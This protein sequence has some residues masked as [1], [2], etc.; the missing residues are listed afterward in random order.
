MATASEIYG[1]SSLWSWYGDGANDCS[2]SAPYDYEPIL[3]SFGEIAV[4]EDTD[5]YQGDSWVLYRDGDR[6]G[7]LCFGWGSCSG[8]DSLQGCSNERELDELIARL[9][10]DVKWGSR[11]EI[12]AFIDKHDWE[13]AWYGRCEPAKRFRRRAAEALQLALREVADDD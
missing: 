9:R 3:A 5:D 12:A 11:E 2:F 1:D 7:Y 4:K 10:D 13:G 6:W 8:C